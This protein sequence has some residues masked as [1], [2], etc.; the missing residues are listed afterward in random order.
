MTFLLD[1]ASLDA[2]RTA[3]RHPWVRGITTNPT[4]LADA[5]EEVETR[6]R[7]LAEFGLPLYYQVRAKEQEAAMAE[8]ERA[9][10][11]V[12]SS[13]V[14]KL[15]P[16][17]LG[18]RLAADLR[19]QTPCCVTAVFTVAQALIARDCGAHEVAVYVSRVDRLRAE[20]LSFGPGVDNGSA[21]VRRIADALT[22][23]E[24]S[25]LAASLKTV[26]EVEEALLAGARSATLGLDLL[27]QLIE[28]EATRRALAAFDERGEGL[29]RS[30]V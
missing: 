9:R 21:L 6:L 13:L 15:P 11:L 20:G 24:T 1:S 3:C 18:F 5:G 22:G 19:Q 2:A 17:E 4:L 10:K 27:E 28:H 8:V 16:D 23:S 14:L 30:P 26:T 29:P 12:G 25:I 7:E